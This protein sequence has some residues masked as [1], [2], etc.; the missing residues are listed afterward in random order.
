MTDTI[1]HRFHVPEISCDHCKASIEGAVGEVEG[2]TMATVDV[3][4][5]T[6]TVEGGSAEAIVAAIDDAG[7]DVDE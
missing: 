1:T 3:G 4:A 2:V 5:K 7:Y 6:V